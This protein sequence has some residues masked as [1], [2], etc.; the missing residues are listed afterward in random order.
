VNE[1]ALVARVALAAV[2]ASGGASKLRAP[3]PFRVTLRDLGLPAPLAT[4][5]AVVVPAWE[6]TTAV[7]LVTGWVPALAVASAVVLAGLFI[8]SAVVA[9]R[10]GRDVPCNCFGTTHER[11][12]RTTVIR[13]SMLLGL[14]MV[15]A[16]A[17][18]VG[19]GGWQPDAVGDWVAASFGGLG[20]V[21]LGRYALV[22]LSWNDGV[23][24]STAATTP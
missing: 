19:D 3:G 18:V 11:L 21:A 5:L 13:S 17:T 16:I 20:V 8:A 23:R 4:P 6:L 22:A 15:V 1:V 14:A 7:L 9:A 10:S 2:L 24:T 12:G